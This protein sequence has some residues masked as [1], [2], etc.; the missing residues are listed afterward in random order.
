MLIGCYKLAL[1]DTHAIAAAMKVVLIFMLRTRVDD[2]W[3]RCVV[4]LDARPSAEL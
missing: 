1:S 3:L 4:V 2:R